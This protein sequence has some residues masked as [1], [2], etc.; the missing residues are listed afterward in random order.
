MLMKEDNNNS[1][2]ILNP[3]SVVASVLILGL[4]GAT[5]KEAG[6]FVLPPFWSHNS[7]LLS[8]AMQLLMCGFAASCSE[9]QLRGAAGGAVRNVGEKSRGRAVHVSKL[10]QQ[11]PPRERV[12]LHH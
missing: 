1:L 10:P 11:I 12:R 6:N 8:V 7:Q 9:K 4:C 5:K 3:L 2:L